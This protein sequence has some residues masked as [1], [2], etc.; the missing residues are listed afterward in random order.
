[1]ITESIKISLIKMIKSRKL[2]PKRTITALNHTKVAI[3]T[4]SKSFALRRN[5][6]YLW[7]SL[8]FTHKMKRN[9]QQLKDLTIK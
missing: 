8:T 2:N 4:K 1:M 9:T 5:K 3:L 6:N 7:L